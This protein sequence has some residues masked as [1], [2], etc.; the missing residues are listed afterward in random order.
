LL[1]PVFLAVGM[2]K[3]LK[4]LKIHHYPDYLS[5][6]APVYLAI[7]DGLE[8]NSTLE[9]LHISMDNVSAEEFSDSL[10]HTVFPFLRVSTTLKSLKIDFEY[11]SSPDPHVAT[12]CLAVV[13]GLRENSWLET[14][15]IDC[16]Q[17]WDGIAPDT[18]ITALESL[19]PHATLK[20]FYIF[21]RIDSFSD[22]EM[23]RV[24]SLV[25]KNYVQTKLDKGLTEHDE[26][27]ELVSIL[28]LNQAGRRYL[29]DDAGS[30]A[31]G[32][33]VLVDVRDDLNCLFYHLLENPLLCDIERQYEQPG[34]PA[35]KV[36]SHGT[37]RIRLTR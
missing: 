4:I 32:V 29:I 17:C 7:R 15:E 34:V 20:E 6:C 26:T 8:K 1:V 33:E 16:H 18:Y 35:A 11:H 10:V 27:G 14:L 9:V 31:K 5:N 37:K 21:P 36:G 3:A 28:R 2:N 25:K 23:K 30:I 19:Q 24:V 22:D 12:S 13:T